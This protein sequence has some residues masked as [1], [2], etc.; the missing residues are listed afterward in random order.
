MDPSREILLNILI[1]MYFI[2]LTQ[3]LFSSY[4]IGSIKP[5]A[6]FYQYIQNKLNLSP[7]E[8]LLIDDTKENTVE[9]KELG[10]EIYYYQNDLKNLK[11]FLS[12]KLDLE[13]YPKP[14]P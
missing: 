13:L 10:W 5:E 6:E 2:D 3:R 11:T 9:A 1:N 14:T 7:K 12:N 8:L 4:Q